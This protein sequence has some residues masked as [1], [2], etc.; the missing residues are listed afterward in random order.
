MTQ[1]I[2]SQ[3]LR[4]VDIYGNSWVFR[5]V[6]RGSPKR[7]LLTT[8][9]SAFVSTRGLV[10]GDRVLFVRGQDS[11]LKVS[12]RRKTVPPVATPLAYGMFASGTGGSS[13]GP[14]GMDVEGTVRMAT[15]GYER[16]CPFTVVY[17][18]RLPGSSPFL[19]PLSTFCLSLLRKQHLRSGS[20][21][22]TSFPSPAFPV[23]SFHPPM[24]PGLKAAGHS[25]RSGE[26]LLRVAAITV[27]LSQGVVVG[28]RPLAVQARI[29]L[30]VGH[31]SAP[32]SNSPPAFPPPECTEAAV[33]AE[34]V[35]R[36]AGS[37]ERPLNERMPR[38]ASTQVDWLAIGQQGGG[39]TADWLVE[40][41]RRD[42]AKVETGEG[43]MES[44]ERKEERADW[45][46]EKRTRERR[47]LDVVYGEGGLGRDEELVVGECKKPRV[48]EKIA[49]GSVLNTGQSSV[50]REGCLIARTVYL[51]LFSDFP[52]LHAHIAA[53][54][55]PALK[56]GREARARAHSTEAKG[57]IGEDGGA[58]AAAAAGAGTMGTTGGTGGASE[59]DDGGDVLAGWR[60]VYEDSDGDTL[61]VG[62]G[63]WT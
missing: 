3:R 30:P 45:A 54:F 5:H 46:N 58:A 7:H 43:G 36:T 9:W 47:A 44:G 4:A 52:A 16:R 48:D 13:M 11:Y 10:A 55:G 61:L 42:G 29:H 63:T 22:T 50:F 56:A 18:P 14:G 34:A 33:A 21:M 27:A 6:Y 31:L 23:P 62:D 1:D 24:P 40:G 49:R 37:A 51:G 57:S 59:S 41:E 28:L 15:M 17:H 8:G 35:A 39:Q 12:I 26:H 38:G 25:G 19:I 53:M 20:L 2:P 60:L 32:R